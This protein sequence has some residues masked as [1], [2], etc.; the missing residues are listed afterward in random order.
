MSIHSKGGTE[1][2]EEKL[3]SCHGGDWA[4]AGEIRPKYHGLGPTSI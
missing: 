1:E 4:S 3:V 2:E